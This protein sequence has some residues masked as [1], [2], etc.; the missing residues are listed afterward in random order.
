[1]LSNQAALIDIRI[2]YRIRV[3]VC[4]QCSSWTSPFMT[5]S[6]RFSVHSSGPDSSIAAH[7]QK[8]RN[9]A[10]TAVVNN[11]AIT[12]SLT[13]LLMIFSLMVWDRDLIKVFKW[14]YFNNTLVK[15]HKTL[16]Y[17]LNSNVLYIVIGF[18][19]H[20]TLQSVVIVQSSFNVLHVWQFTIFILK[21]LS[22]IHLTSKHTCAK[23][24]LCMHF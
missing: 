1:M 3:L 14:Q 6:R 8:Y 20:L 5:I 15:N 18:W 17:S 11:S 7:H 4:R 21:T 19:S 16:V 12:R 24:K 2:P 9:G 10:F 22:I 23:V 13:R